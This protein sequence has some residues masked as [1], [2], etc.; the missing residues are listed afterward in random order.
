MYDQ[1]NVGTGIHVSRLCSDIVKTLGEV[2]MLVFTFSSPNIARSDPYGSQDPQTILRFIKQVALMS[3]SLYR[4]THVYVM[5]MSLSEHGVAN[6]LENERKRK[7]IQM[8]L[9]DVAM[10]LKQFIDTSRAYMS[11]KLGPRAFHS[12]KARN[13]PALKGAKLSLDKLE[14]ILEQN[15]IVKD[16]PASSIPVSAVLKETE[17]QGRR[18]EMK[19]YEENFLHAIQSLRDKIDV[20]ATVC[21]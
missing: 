21:D 5:K 3:R 15:A 14:V 18:Q 7:V 10:A 8:V 19:E 2:H 16:A 4:V 12:E 17:E 20:L 1:V 13:P 9:R 11:M 6:E